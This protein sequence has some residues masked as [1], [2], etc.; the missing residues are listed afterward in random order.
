MKIKLHYIHP[1]N[2]GNLMMASA[3]IDKFSELYKGEAIFYVDVTNDEEMKRL[4]KSLEKD[5]KIEKDYL[6][7]ENFRNIN[8]SKMKKVINL[9]KKIKYE[10]NSYDCHIYLGGDCISEYY[11]IRQFIIDAITM[12]FISKKKK[13]F[14]VGQTI[15]P[16]S[17][18][19]K[20]L[21]K[22]CLKKCYIFTRDDSCYDYLKDV[23]KLPNVNKSRDLAF[24]DI[25]HQNDIEVSKEILEKYNCNGEYISVVASGLI[26]SYTDDEN[27]YI[28]EYI[29]IITNIIDKT[30][31]KVLLLAHVIHNPASDDTRAIREIIKKIPDKYKS[32]IMVVDELIMPH[33]ARALLGNGKLTITGRMHAAVSSLNKTVIPICL[34]YSVKYQG[35]VGNGFNLKN[36]IIECG[37]KEIWKQKEVSKIVNEKVM[38]VLNN[39]ENL[40]KEIEIKLEET[41]KQSLEQI[42]DVIRIMG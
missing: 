18:Y 14:L 24:L 25:P 10:R 11:G 1:N 2:Y 35:V 42:K 12:K 28:D 33:E 4:K 16:F 23:I 6:I 13:T 27:S 7:E 34:S 26:R 17:G 39:S 29:R 5:I 22:N 37:N 40:K 20:K 19:R 21:V 8:V 31:Y 41:K 3:F 32:N 30:N 38:Y 15:G 36:L 9:I